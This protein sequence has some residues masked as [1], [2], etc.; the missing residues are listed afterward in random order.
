MTSDHPR[1]PRLLRGAL[2]VYPSQDAGTQPTVIPFQFNP[3][4]VK[5]TLASRT[6][7]SEASDA[8]AS[9]EDANRVAGPP[10]ETLTLAVELDA[11]EHL[12]RPQG[13]DAV[14][15]HGL[16][17][18][19][20]TLEMLMYPPGAQILQNEQL[21]EAGE[22]QVR[23][24]ELPLTLLVWGES[25][26]VPV[27]ITGFSISEE[28]FDT[29]LSPIRARVDL[30]MQVLTYVELQEDSIGRDAYMAYQRRKEEF[31]SDHRAGKGVERIRALLPQ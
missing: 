17:G 25:R 6:P 2:A 13:N 29:N 1:S 10:I 4:A 30:S 24:E 22:V 27:R 26:V 9:Q 7:P 15:E 31:A 5:R 21:A 19:L 12:A 14:I 23:P 28:A 20:A 16:H 8:G 11:T 3:E 18:H